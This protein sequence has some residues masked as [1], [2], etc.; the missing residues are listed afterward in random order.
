[1]TASTVTPATMASASMTSSITSERSQDIFER[2]SLQ[3]ARLAFYPL[4]YDN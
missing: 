3:A 4:L 2:Y 1:V